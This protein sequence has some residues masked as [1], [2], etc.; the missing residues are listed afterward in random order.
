MMGLE[1]C[2]RN[3]DHIV[4]VMRYFPH[5]KF[6][7]Y[8]PTMDL[9]DVREYM[10]N[11]LVALRRVHQF[12]IIHRDIK[13]S[14]FLHNTTTNQFSLVDFGL[15]HDAPVKLQVSNKGR[16]PLVIEHKPPSV[17]KENVH[18]H[19]DKLAAP[20]L[21][22]S[23]SKVM[24]VDD[25]KQENKKSEK[26]E[27]PKKKI[28]SPSKLHS[29]NKRVAS[30]PQK[31][32]I[33]SPKGKVP[34][35]QTKN[36]REDETF[37]SPPA[38]PPPRSTHPAASTS[39]P[40]HLIKGKGPL[41]PT[42]SR[43]PSSANTAAV[44]NAGV[45]KRGHPSPRRTL[46]AHRA[47][48]AQA[49]AGRKQGME[50]DKNASTSKRGSHHHL[51]TLRTCQCFGR[52]MICSIC[53]SRSIQSAP[54]AGTPGFR[55]PEVLMK[56]PMQSTAVDMW[57]AG[58]I[59]LSLL[60]GRYPFFRANDDLTCLSQIISLLGTEE[61]QKAAE[62]YGKLLTCRPV[63]RPLDLKHLCLRLRSVSSE[64]N[65]APVKAWADIPDSAID[66]LKKLLDPDPFTRITAEKALQHAFF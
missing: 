60:S 65:T 24:D 33:K 1:L 66:L 63:T 37:F 34:V 15:A 52:A 42:K 57:S 29:P 41:S 44:L 38:H 62:K 35:S 55:A 18:I 61:V 22:G 21:F 49:E 39:T 59:F 25:L 54:R 17:Q 56:H 31:A 50:G 43:Q 5:Q 40:S 11:L 6:Q 12:D 19:S 58:V 4:I 45:V 10:R 20:S 3:K 47:L 46:L 30:S 16:S 28:L 8:L 14:N 23:K 9:E 7:E 64:Q 48:V 27:S 32:S 13:P 26:V 51:G 36:K 2:L 53:N